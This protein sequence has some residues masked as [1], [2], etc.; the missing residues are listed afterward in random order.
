MP[1]YLPIGAGRLPKLDLAWLHASRTEEVIQFTRTVTLTSAA[2][3][4]AVSVV[5]D[6]E[7]P[8]GFTLFV[9]DWS[10][11]VNGGTLWGTVTSVKLQD[12]SA[13]DFSTIAVAALAANAYVKPNTANVTVDPAMAI[14]TGGTAGKGL[15]IKANANGTGSDLVVTVV[16]YLKKP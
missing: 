8:A 9:E 11:K 16:G 14:N 10:A 12:T 15:Q 3:G 5:T 7:V 13:V 1:T 6:A 4:T 2:A